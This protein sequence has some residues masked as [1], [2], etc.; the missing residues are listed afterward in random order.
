M[1][2]RIVKTY[3]LEKLIDSNDQ[4]G[5]INIFKNGSEFVSEFGGQILSLKSSPKLS[6]CFYATSRYGTLL[7]FLLPFTEL[8]ESFR[9]GSSPVRAVISSREVF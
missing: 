7:I 9:V 8:P 2:V 5:Y 1:S 4:L 6:F 3:M